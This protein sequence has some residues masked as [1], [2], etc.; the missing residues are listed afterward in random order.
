MT[1]VMA[2]K[3]ILLSEMGALGIKANVNDMVFQGGKDPG[4]W[5]R[6]GA[7]VCVI[8]EGVGLPNDWNCKDPFT[9]WDNLGK[10]VSMVLNRNVYFEWI[11]GC[12]AAL[13]PA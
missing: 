10:R 5:T 9:W 12:V 8:H 4:G 11:N 3:T 2:T 6:D 1:A 13:Y 7:L